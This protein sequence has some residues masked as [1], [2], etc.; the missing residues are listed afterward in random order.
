MAEQLSA[1]VQLKE[2]KSYTVLWQGQEIKFMENA[3]KQVAGTDLINHLKS[4]SQLMVDVHQPAPAPKKAMPPH[5]AARQQAIKPKALV[6]K[7]EPLPEPEVEVVEPEPEAEPEPAAEDDDA[8][9]LGD[10]MDGYEGQPEPVMEDGEPEPE[11]V[12]DDEPQELVDVVEDVEELPPTKPGKP[13]PAK[14]G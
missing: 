3:A 4:I 9:P 14:K 6:R 2:G 1:T 11:P 7:P 5:L 8:N 10:G 13:K 12:A